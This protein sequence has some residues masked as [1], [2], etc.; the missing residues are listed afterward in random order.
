[1]K[2]KTL[3]LISFGKFHNKTIEL[4]DHFN[5][6]FGS[7]EAGKTTV[8]HF[9]E[10]MFFG[11]YKPYRKRRTYSEEYEH[12]KPRDREMYSGILIY[13]D[14]EKRLIRI[15]RDFNKK[16]DGVLIFDELTGADITKDYP[17]DA[18]TRQ[19]LPLGKINMNSVLYNNTINI[20]QMS[21]NADEM[22]AK[23]VNDRLVSLS[24]DFADD[25]SINRIKKDLVSRKDAIGS[26]ARSRSPLGEAARE[27][28]S[29]E[30]ILSEHEEALKRIEE[31]KKK[32]LQY[33]KNIQAAEKKYSE[34]QFFKQKANKNE[35][36]SMYNKISSLQKECTEISTQLSELE[37]YKDFESQT[38]NRLKV[39]QSNIEGVEERV[40]TLHEKREALVRE[41]E[42]SESK[43]IQ[44]NS[45]VSEKSR[46]EIRMDYQKLRYIQ[47]KGPLKEKNEPKRSTSDTMPVSIEMSPLLLGGGILLG[48]LAVLAGLLF[49]SG[50]TSIIIATIGWFILLFSI[51]AF[52][53]KSKGKKMVGVQ[54]TPQKAYTPMNGLEALFTKYNVSDR[55][56]LIEYMKNAESIFIQMDQLTLEQKTLSEKRDDVVNEIAHLNSQKEDYQIE[57]ETEL[58][59]VGVDHLKEYA[60][61]LQKS[62]A[63]QSLL[64]DYQLKNELLN[65]LKDGNYVQTHSR[66]ENDEDEPVIYI[67]DGGEEIRAQ[68]ALIAYRDGISRLE[69]KNSMLAARIDTD[70][71][72]KDYIKELKAKIK[73]YEDDQEAINCAIDAFEEISK[74]THSHAAPE[75]NQK[76][77]QCL[78]KITNKYHT[79]KVDNQLQV[80]IEDPENGRLLNINELSAGTMDQLY[81]ALRFS[82]G[83]ALEL[84]QKMPFILDDPF[85]QYDFVRKS[86]A[87]K[88]LNTLSAGRQVLLFTCSSDEKQI[89]DKLQYTYSGMVL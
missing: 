59:Q 12:Y 46:G 64:R 27:L 36:N 71:D 30:G 49:L 75:L 54:P 34:Y 11:F 5:L 4:N 10:G 24:P 19:A 61:G 67:T 26:V 35:Q 77:G 48:V 38:Y 31:N 52:I 62:E 55:D 76:I 44:L 28:A 84:N 70:M 82:V 29:Y 83:D 51:F 16:Q 7:N 18:V 1:M 73:E 78:Q 74:E 88:F 56:E 58:K 68:E 32:I 80:R 14:E 63:Y 69:G 89:L 79:V 15:E 21:G 41:I 50:I 86:E 2:I 3:K 47:E 87:I 66:E 6:I 85:V 72:V 8:Q 42:A 33:Q 81:L 60:S 20:Q 13:E 45:Q 37:A 53:I 40:D 17:Y 23:E 39:L 9:I 22:L 25:I 43:M 65:E 57:L